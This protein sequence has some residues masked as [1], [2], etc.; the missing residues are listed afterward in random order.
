MD[1]LD[2][3]KKQQIKQ[4]VMEIIKKYKKSLTNKIKRDNYC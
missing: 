3:I 1:I 4:I 2:T